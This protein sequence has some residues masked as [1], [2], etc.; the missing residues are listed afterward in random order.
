[1][2][3]TPTNILK[4]FYNPRAGC[5][6]GCLCWPHCVRVSERERDII[7]LFSI[8]TFV[9]TFFFVWFSYHFPANPKLTVLQQS[10]W[11]PQAHEI[12]TGFY[13][14]WT[15]IGTSQFDTTIYTSDILSLMKAVKWVFKSKES[16][17]PLLCTCS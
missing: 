9:S 7:I 5:C 3:E 10:F 17:P 8:W 11:S 16:N 6:I 2:L 15:L 14:I 13:D 4:P 12:K 1:M